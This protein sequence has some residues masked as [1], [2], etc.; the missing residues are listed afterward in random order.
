MTATEHKS[1][2]EIATNTPY[3]ALTGSYGM[4]IIRN[5]KKID[6]PITAPR[7]TYILK[8]HS[9]LPPWFPLLGG[10]FTSKRGTFGSVS[11]LDTMCCLTFGRK[12]NICY[13]GGA[14]GSIYVWNGV[15][16]EKTIKAHEGPCFSM[17]SLDKVG[18]RET[19][20]THCPLET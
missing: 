5:L 16:L 3:L 8:F 2:F 13:T 18:N 9:P 6:S 20:L 19:S 1:D 7:C 4:S 14:N 17:H 10:G 11:K 15:T 12:A